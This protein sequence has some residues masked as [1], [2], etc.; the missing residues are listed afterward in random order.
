[1]NTWN[2]VEDVFPDCYQHVLC[3]RPHKFQVICKANV[4]TNKCFFYNLET[5]YP[6]NEVTHWMKLPNNPAEN[7]DE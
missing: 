7:T 1:M 5:G 6:E 2:K 3:A 4:T